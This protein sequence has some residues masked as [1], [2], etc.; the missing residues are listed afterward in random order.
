MG[1]SSVGCDKNVS[2]V[3]ALL[4][5]PTEK[6]DKLLRQLIKH[7][8]FKITVDPA[9]NTRRL[10]CSNTEKPAEELEKAGRGDD[11]RKDGKYV[12]IDRSQLV[13]SLH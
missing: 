10:V 9:N 5:I 6:A 1:K 12:K 2:I 3:K 13:D 7:E 11:F 4:N 8:M